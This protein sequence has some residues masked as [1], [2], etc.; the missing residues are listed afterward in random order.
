MAIK[1]GIDKIK[2]TSKTSET[3]AHHDW[4]AGV[5]YDAINGPTEINDDEINNDDPIDDESEDTFNI[6]QTKPIAETLAH[7][8]WI[9]GVDYDKINDPVEDK[10]EG[11][12]DVDQTNP[13]AETLVEN[14][15][16]YNKENNDIENVIDE[17]I[18]ELNNEVIPEGEEFN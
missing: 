18:D 4:I 11:T 7:H 10:S 5:D 12:F 16:T 14:V 6:D 8:D 9:A 1:Q 17:M 2:F 13:I 15:E 3:L